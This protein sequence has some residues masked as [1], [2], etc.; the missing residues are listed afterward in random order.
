MLTKEWIFNLS[1][2]Y[3]ILPR[4]ILIQEEDFMSSTAMLVGISNKELRS[5]LSAQDLIMLCSWPICWLDQQNK[6]FKEISPTEPIITFSTLVNSESTKIFPTSSTKQ[7]FLWTSNKEKWSSWVLSMLDKWKREFSVL[8]T[9]WC[10][11]KDICLSTQAVTSA[12]MVM[13]VYSLD[14]LEQEKLLW[15]L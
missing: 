15:V 1:E 13:Y 3:K 8:W 4:I 6:S 10:Q 9:I 7:L 12:R 14:F 11:R 2:S 5:E